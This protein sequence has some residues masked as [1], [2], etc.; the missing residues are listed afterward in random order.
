[1]PKQDPTEH[2]LFIAD[3]VPGSRTSIDVFGRGAA[4]A[5]VAK[6]A[7]KTANTSATSIF[8]VLLMTNLHYK[9]YLNYYISFSGLIQQILRRCP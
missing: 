3:P 1:M 7:M 2:G 9:Q 8:E 6:T 4:K 5:D